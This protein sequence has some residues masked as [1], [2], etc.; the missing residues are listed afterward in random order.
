MSIARDF[1]Y[2]PMLFDGVKDP[3]ERVKAATLLAISVGTLGISIDK[4]FNPIL[5]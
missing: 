2:A 3:L 1:C 5:G 4:P